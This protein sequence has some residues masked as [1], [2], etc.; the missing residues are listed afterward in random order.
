MLD[1]F[2]YEKQVEIT[3]FIKK[4]VM[5]FFFGAWRNILVLDIG[6]VTNNGV[7]LIF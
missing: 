1:R 7:K 6:R 4:A 3:P 5:E 2:F